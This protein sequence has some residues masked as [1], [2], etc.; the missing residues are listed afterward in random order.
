MWISITDYTDYEINSRT[1]EIR[2]KADKNIVSERI[3]SEG[4]IRVILNGDS[5]HKHVIIAEQFVPNDDPEHKTCVDHINHIRTDNRLTNLRWVSYSENALNKSSHKG[6]GY[7]F[8]DELPYDSV[9][10]DRYNQHAIR[11][12]V[13]YSYEFNCFYKQVADNVFRI[14]HQQSRSKN[15]GNPFVQTATTG[16]SSVRL[17]NERIRENIDLYE[18]IN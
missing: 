3:D 2:K 4:Y 8:V 5:L 1:F 14:M 15:N 16:R 10:I 6:I 12:K 17:Y 9:I 11:D 7:E 13:F 18:T